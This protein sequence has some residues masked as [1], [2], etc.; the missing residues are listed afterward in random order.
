VTESYRTGGGS[1]LADGDHEKAE[2]EDALADQP[3]SVRSYGHGL[4]YWIRRAGM[5]FLW[6]M[7]WVML[8]AW[9]R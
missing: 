3:A 6:V 9:S 8:T 4:S 7:L 5:S 1:P 2:A